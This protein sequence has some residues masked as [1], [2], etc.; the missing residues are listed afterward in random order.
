MIWKP[1]AAMSRRPVEAEAARGPAFASL[2]SGAVVPGSQ[3]DAR[4]IALR[5]LGCTDG[6]RDQA[7]A[8]FSD[9]ELAFCHALP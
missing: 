4:A 6:S 8:P 7:T 5:K 2:E 3:I 1:I 9:S